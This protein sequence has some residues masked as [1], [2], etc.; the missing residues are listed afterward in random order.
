MVNLLQ[1]N[2]AHFSLHKSHDRIGVNASRLA[3]WQLLDSPVR[4]LPAPAIGL[5]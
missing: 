2:R 3:S 1:F 5:A 4:S